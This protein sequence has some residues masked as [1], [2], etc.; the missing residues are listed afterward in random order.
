MAVRPSEKPAAARVTDAHDGELVVFLIGMRINRWRAV[1]QWWPVVM[2]MPKMLRELFADPESGLLGARTMVGG[3]LR[4]I[5]LVQYW[6]DADRL[7]AYAG[8][9]DREHRPAWQA[10]NR[11]ARAAEAVG[12][13][14]ETYLVPA[15]RHESVYVNMPAYGLGQASG[16]QP[17]GPR[18]EHAAQRLNRSA[19]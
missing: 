7:I 9:A 19:E 16:T 18:G 3:G 15:G 11:N 8:A 10:F 5:T 14:H 6:T 13:W 17:V 1:R 2:A 4:E 12:I